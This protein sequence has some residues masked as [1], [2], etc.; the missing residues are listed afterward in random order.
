[1][2]HLHLLFRFWTQKAFFWSST[3]SFEGSLAQ[4]VVEE[5]LDDPIEISSGPRLSVDAS[6]SDNVTTV[7]IVTKLKHH[8]P[9]KKKEYSSITLL[10]YSWVPSTRNTMINSVFFI[11]LIA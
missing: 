5:N 11:L 8:I 2:T 7:T 4:L 6:C 1:M 3:S 9:V 10:G